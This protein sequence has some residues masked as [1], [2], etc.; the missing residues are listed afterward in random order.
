MADN[1][2]SSGGP[3]TV[4]TKQDPNGVHH[5]AMVPEHLYGDLPI[6]VKPESPFPI[7]NPQEI[8]LLTAILVEL[9][10]QNS[11]IYAFINTEVEPTETMRAV[12][13]DWP[14]TP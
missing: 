7:G 13:K 1:V 12:F 3:L 6:P 5:Q 4:A 14:V 2:L 8:E 9:R 11:M 10:V